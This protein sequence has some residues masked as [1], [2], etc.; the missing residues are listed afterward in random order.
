M[1][2]SEILNHL[3]VN[4]PNLIDVSFPIPSPHPDLSLI[5]PKSIKAII[6]GADPTHIVNGN[7]VEI[8]KVFGLDLKY[9]PYWNG[10]NNNIKQVVG[11]SVA[12]VYVQNVCRNYFKCETSQNKDWVT[13]ARKYWIPFLKA[14]LNEKFDKSIPIFITT[15]FILSAALNNP[16]KK[17]IA[18]ELYANCK[19]IEKDDNL[20]ER[21]IIPFYRHFKYNLKNWPEY[22]MFLKSKINS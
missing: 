20:F 3:V 12:N 5:D 1:N 10:I 13:I 18:S 17:I 16:A 9:S 4:Y 2:Q 21:E 6:L 15:E 22:N 11:L 7:P 8:K 14:E 19:S